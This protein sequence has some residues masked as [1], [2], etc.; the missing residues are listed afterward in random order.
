MTKHPWRARG[1]FRSPSYHLFCRECGHQQSSRY[2][3]GCAE[4]GSQNLGEKRGLVFDALE[5][6]TLDLTGVLDWDFELIETCERYEHRRL[7][8]EEVRE[9]LL[10]ERG[11]GQ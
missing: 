6:P 3:S 4:C 9:R 7:T 11:L 5:M 8:M 1:V 10:W 2:K